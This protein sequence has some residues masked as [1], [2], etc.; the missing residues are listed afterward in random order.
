[1]YQGRGGGGMSCENYRLH[2]IETLFLLPPGGSCI[3]SAGTH[4]IEGL[5][6]QIQNLFWGGVGSFT[7]NT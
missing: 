2:S 1:M 3:K 6:P 4:Y 7:P 5:D